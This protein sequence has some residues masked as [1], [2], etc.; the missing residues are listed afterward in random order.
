MQLKKLGVRYI[1]GT[2][3]ESDK[4]ECVRTNETI[5]TNV[6]DGILMIKTSGSAIDIAESEAFRSL[7][8]DIKRGARS[9]II[10]ITPFLKGVYREAGESN[11]NFAQH[12]RSMLVTRILEESLKS[13]KELKVF[14]MVESKLKDY[15]RAR[16]YC[17]RFGYCDTNMFQV[18]YRK[19][20]F[21]GFPRLPTLNEDNMVADLAKLRRKPFKR[22]DPDNTMNSPPFWRVFCDGYGGQQSLGG[23]SY[24]G[25]VGAYLFVCCS[26]GSTD[27]RLYSSHKQFPIALHQFLVRVQA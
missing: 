1:G 10:E 11:L 4:I 26:T 9:P 12:D 17:R 21:G 16:L 13:D 23:E 19:E 24:E 2:F 6:V 18:M 20:E 5:P 15:E 27:I 8:N 25:A 14:L 3:D 22:N 7:V